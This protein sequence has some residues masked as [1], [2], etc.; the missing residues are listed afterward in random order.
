MYL[1]IQ[2]SVNALLLQ[3]MCMFINDI[4]ICALCHK[5]QHIISYQ[6]RTQAWRKSADFFVTDI[7]TRFYPRAPY[8]V[9]VD[10]SEVHFC[11]LICVYRSHDNTIGIMTGS[12]AKVRDFPVLHVRKPFW[13]PPS[14]LSNETWGGYFYFYVV[15]IGTRIA[16]CLCTHFRMFCN[17]H[18]HI[19]HIPCCRP[20]QSL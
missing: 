13:G 1:F 12:M 14:V 5:I 17:I 8:P 7:N 18:P 15:T 4:I 16:S 6:N 2:L 20:T 19:K 3:F 9:A 10:Q 11:T